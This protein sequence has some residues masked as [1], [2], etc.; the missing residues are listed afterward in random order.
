[1]KEN[2]SLIKEIND[3][4]RELRLVRTQVHDNKSQSSISKKKLSSSDLTALTSVE[5]R[6]LV[7]RLN[8]EEEAERIIQL[9]RMEIQRLKMQ[10]QGQ[11]HSLIPPSSSTKLPVLTT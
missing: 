7:A 3:L 11:S 2:V 8:F 6:G 9:Q 4:R 1:M 10:M 5:G